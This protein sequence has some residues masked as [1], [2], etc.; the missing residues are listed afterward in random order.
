MLRWLKTHNQSLTSMAAILVS[1]IALY[2]AWD[3]SRVM[4]AQQHGAVVPVIQIDGFLS[5]TP[6]SRS[7]GLRLNNNGVGPA[8]IEHVQLVRDGEVTGDWRPVTHRLPSDFD[9]SWSSVVG[10][11]LAPGGAVEPVAFT[12]DRADLDDPA[13]ADLLEEWV[14]WDMQVCYCSVFDRCWTVTADTGARTPVRQCPVSEADVFEAF[15]QTDTDQTLRRD[16]PDAGPEILAEPA[17]EPVPD[18]N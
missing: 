13:F 11:V 15:G 2:V 18:E 16:M 1:V 5:S 17:G 4:R 6:E 3:Q 12:W 10:R 14:K 7:M 9:V 8:M